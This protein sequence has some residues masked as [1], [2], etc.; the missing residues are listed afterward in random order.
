MANSASVQPDGQVSIRQ[1]A[2]RHSSKFVSSRRTLPLVLLVLILVFLYGQF[3]QPV[4]EYFYPAIKSMMLETSEVV[5]SGK[6]FKALEVQ[7]SLIKESECAYKNLVFYSKDKITSTRRTDIA[8]DLHPQLVHKPED[9]SRRP[10]EYL[11]KPWRLTGV[12]VKHHY[13]IG[14][15][16]HDCPYTLWETVTIVGPYRIP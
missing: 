4:Y 15:L 3:G 1:I 5:D 10:G 11:M 8:L 2:N 14:T 9:Y 16:F 7:F 6:K 13:I 12:P